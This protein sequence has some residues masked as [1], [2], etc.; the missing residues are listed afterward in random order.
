MWFGVLGPVLVEDAGTRVAVQ[1]AQL[2]MLLVT[3]LADANSVVSVADLERALWGQNP[4]ASARASLYNQV[5]R[6]R[7]QLGPGIGARIRTEAPGYLIEVRDG[8]LDEQVFLDRWALGRTALQARD[9]A[10]ASGHLESALVLWRGEPGSD[11]PT[12]A[13]DITHR[14]T[15]IRLMALEGRLEAELNLGRHREIIAEIRAL[16]G[17]YPLYEAFHG[18]LMLAL[19][20]NSRQAD[21]LET[22]R[23]LRRTLLDELGVEP[24]SALQHLHRRIL[25]ADPGLSAP[26]HPVDRAGTR[27]TGPAAPAQ[28]LGGSRRQLPGD[29]RTFVG[30]TRQLEELIAAA[31][32]D[33]VSPDA[34]R[35]VTYV[36][37]GMAGIGK[38]A[39]AIHT[40]HRLRDQ[41]PDGQLFLDM[42]GHTSGLAPLSADEALDWLLRCLNVPA[43]LIPG[44]LGQRAALYRDRLAGT[45]TLLILDNAF[46]TAQVRP[47]L[48]GTS[49]CMVLITSRKRLAGLDDAYSITLDSLSVADASALLHDVAGQGRIPMQHSATGELAA[50]CG[51]MPLALRIAAA[52]LRHHRALRIEDLVNRLRDENTR[53]DQLHDGDRNLAAVFDSSYAA[54]PEAEQRMLRSVGLIPGPD[55]DTYT[56]ANLTG[57]DLGTAERLLDSLADHNLLT[58][59]AAGRYR[60]HDLVRVYARSLSAGDSDEKHFDRLLDYFQYTARACDRYLA[61]RIRPGAAPADPA[62]AA[63]P[64]IRDRA[65]ALAWLRSERACLLAAVSI[66]VAHGSNT[67]TVSLTAALAGFLDQDGSWREATALHQT[68]VTAAHELGDRFG[69]ADAL[70]SLGRAYEAAGD[71]PA[72]TARCELALAIY[73]ELD[74][75]QGEANALH[76]QG[77]LLQLTNDY[78]ASAAR[79]EHALLAYRKLG[80]KLG[81]ANSLWELGRLRLMTRDAATAADLASGA[82]AVY[83]QLGNRLG[84]ANTLWDLARARQLAGSSSDAADLVA[85]ALV[86]YQELDYRIGEA[87]A[88]CELG[89]FSSEAGNHADATDLIGRSVTIYREIGSP[90]GEAGSCLELARARLMIGDL[91]GAATLLERALMLFRR[92]GNRHGEANSLHDLGRT[93]LAAADFPSAAGLLSSALDLF[94]D[95]DDSLGQAEVLIS[96]ASLTARTTGPQAAADI[97]RRAASLA[98]EIDVGQSVAEALEGAA[99]CEAE[100]GDRLAAAADLREAVM[101]YQRIGSAKADEALVFLD[102]LEGAAR[103]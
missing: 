32:P 67:R 89:R 81:E 63:V 65:G 85:A 87:N 18:Q 17:E 10:A 61:R 55:F 98:R 51:R 70:L 100:Y 47:L 34:A 97:Y 79:Q 20:R 48:P 2:R 82:L 27:I 94:K 101:I 42:Q 75:Q 96:T 95:L 91:D 35:A 77:H 71:Y 7:R 74:D 37:D 93:R 13:A 12:A 90:L 4:P 60:F 43:K 6:L 88:L 72:A 56:A 24:S 33:P 59:H 46:S 53:L 66:S 39:L 29:T 31:S 102:A 30:R 26:T 52:R 14:L 64:D 99:R 22:F 8:E 41:F 19:Y 68:A 84:E 62:P 50:L 1:S 5:M 15:E 28:D 73:R 23:R 69:E 92:I 16:T 36:I 57:A 54:L 76:V 40:A 83:R 21:A 9:W 49:G 38:S 3:L 80:D 86:I 45:R 44:D 11:L 25:D 58:Q 78:P 103:Y